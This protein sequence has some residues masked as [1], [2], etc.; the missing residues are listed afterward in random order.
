MALRWM[1]TKHADIPVDPV[2][3]IDAIRI[4]KVVFAEIKTLNAQI[5]D[6]F[7]SH[8]TQFTVLR[9]AV[10]FE[11]D[12]LRLYPLKRDLECS[13]AAAIG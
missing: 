8:G 3:S 4:T 5:S 13:Q 10:I 1:E 12:N 11:T 9:A 2:A 7:H 6:L